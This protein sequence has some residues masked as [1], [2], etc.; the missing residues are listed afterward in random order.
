MREDWDVYSSC[1]PLAFH[2]EWQLCVLAWPSWPSLIPF[3]E[4]HAEPK[5]FTPARLQ[6]FSPDL[7]APAEY[8]KSADK[9]SRSISYSMERLLV[10]M[11]VN[12]L[13]SISAL[14]G[15]VM[16]GDWLNGLIRVKAQII[17]AV[18]REVAGFENLHLL[19]V[20]RPLEASVSLNVLDAQS[21]VSY[22]L[23]GPVCLPGQRAATLQVTWH[24]YL[25]RHV[26][27]SLQELETSKKV[28]MK[29]Q[30]KAAIE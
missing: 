28:N 30:D 3:Y 9:G 26:N 22:M 1:S 12:H 4:D 8:Q 20:K 27:Q 7:L 24:Y 6:V 5:P 10:G 17:S 21:V 23:R 11:A 16:H 18:Q 25:H 15:T 29:C 13:T 19:N 2:K 14:W